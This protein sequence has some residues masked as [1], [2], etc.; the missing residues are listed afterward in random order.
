MSSADDGARRL[1]VAHSGGDACNRPPNHQAPVKVYR[2]YPIAAVV[3]LSTGLTIGT[4]QYAFGE[5]SA[6]L[7]AHFGWSQTALNLSLTLA[8][9]SGALAPFLGRAM[10]RWGA[11]PVTVISL[12]LV[13]AGF[14]LR[15]LIDSL[16]QWYL[17]SALVYAGFPGATTLPAGKLVGLWFP[18]TRGRVMG[19][20]TA[21]NNVGGL[22]MPPLAAAMIALGGWQWG[23]LAFGVLLLL[24]ALVALVT[25]SEDEALVAREM[26]ASGR[27]GAVHAARRLAGSGVTLQQALRSRRFYLVLFGLF[28]ATFTYQGVLTQLRQHFAENGFTPVLA[29]TGLAVIAAMGIGAKL[30]FGRASERWTARR[31]CVVS[32]AFQT[33]GLVIMALANSVPATWCGIVVYALGFGGLGALLVLVVQ[34]A[35]GM[36]AFGSI[37]GVVQMAMIGSLAGAPALAG[38]LHD[39]TG[40]FTGAFLIIAAIFVTAIAS[41]LAAGDPEPTSP[42]PN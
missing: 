30:A 1:P 4:T 39:R 36:R 13:A 5:F 3:F 41:L 32:V 11:R 6:P 20:V 2:G 8:V 35:F 38:W 25:I 24:L 12:L 33:V 23:Y 18:A 19:A 34:E 15:P 42:P 28:G 9:V 17:F 27:A 26:R 22:T 21:G 40:S 10:D 31:A 7:R 37:F 29:T 16:W 14:L